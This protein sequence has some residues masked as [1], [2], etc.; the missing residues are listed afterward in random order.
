MAGAL[1]EAGV[2]LEE[3]TDRVSVVAKAM[4]ECQLRAREGQGRSR[5]TLDQEQVPRSST[6]GLPGA[7]GGF[8]GNG[9]FGCLSRASLPSLR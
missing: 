7:V 9:S 1:A 8:P 4:G 3:I 6:G 5:P 2:G